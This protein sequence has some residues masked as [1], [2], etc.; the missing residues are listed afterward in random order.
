VTD[1]M[2]LSINEVAFELGVHRRT[3][4]RL[5][6]KGILESRQFVPGGRRLI[7]REAL[8]ELRRRPKPDKS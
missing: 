3:V 7:P 1:A 6:D 5:L 4:G 2:F 8:E